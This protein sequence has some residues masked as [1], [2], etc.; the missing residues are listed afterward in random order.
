M[1]TTA[2]VLCFIVLFC[3][4]L[5]IYW[6]HTLP[7]KIAEKRGH[8]QLDAIKACSLVGLLMFPFW[9][10]ALVWAFIKRPTLEASS[11][12]GNAVESKKSI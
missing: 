11:E 4:I 9:M 12:N 7:G 5:A 6:V 8:P 3:I 10:V 1:E 2:L